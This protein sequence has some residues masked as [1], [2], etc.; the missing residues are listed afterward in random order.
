MFT[1]YTQR[2]LPFVIR[3]PRG[4]GSQVDWKTPLKTIEIGKGEWVNKGE[5]LAVISLGPLGVNALSAIESLKLEGINPS[6]IN[7]RFLKPLDT[8]LLLQV[9][10]THQTMLTI[11]DGTEF[12]GLYS[13]VSEFLSQSKLNNKLFHIAIPDK[14]IEHGD[15]KSLHTEL[16]FDVQSM[17]QFFKKCYDND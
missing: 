17:I 14:F 11:E 2:S 4:S 5:K 15:M 6:L 1:A 13:A 3:Y 7:L 8:D 12:G 10:Q 16:G 9:A